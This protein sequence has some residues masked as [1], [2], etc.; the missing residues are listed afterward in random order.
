MW[1]FA[2]KK[3]LVDE[4][5]RDVADFKPDKHI[6]RAWSVEE[7]GRIIAACDVMTGHYCDIESPHWW[8]A[9]LW[10][11]YDT[12]LRVAAALEL[13]TSDL[14]LET[15]W[16]SVPAD[17]QKQKAEQVF[18]L[19]PDTLRVIVATNPAGREWLLPF[20]YHFV[21][22]T[23]YLRLRLNRILNAA[24]LPKTCKDKFHKIRRTTATLVAD[25]AGDE[26]AQKHM[27]HSSLALT[28]IAISTPSTSAAGSSRPRNRRGR[29][30]SATNRR[31]RDSPN[32]KETS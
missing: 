22:R 16:L 10:L 26:A 8:R 24:G 2:W 17:V 23:K 13:T 32:E 30:P 14:D 27:G 28:R 15:G 25:L 6:P 9:F 4:L 12:G 7:F 21:G 5:P 18:K 1:R 3:R 29:N 11:L 31:P 20:P 19:H